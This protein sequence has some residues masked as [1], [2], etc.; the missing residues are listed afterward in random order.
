MTVLEVG[1]S[2]WDVGIFEAPSEIIGHISVL[3]RCLAHL[4]VDPCRSLV[5]LQPPVLVIK[6][7]ACSSVT[8]WY[9]IKFTL[10]LLMPV[11][12]GDLVLAEGVCLS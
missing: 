7:Y 6:T 8:R 5:H 2:M 10:R 9:S 12:G 11:I 4:I 3:T 1:N